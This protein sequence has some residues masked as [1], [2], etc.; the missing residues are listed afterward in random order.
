MSTN[1]PLVRRTHRIIVDVETTVNDEPS[2]TEDARAE[3]VR[4]HQALV[5]HL[6][7]HPTRLE[8]L[9]RS[10][11]VEALLPAKKLLEAEYGWGRTSDQQVL[12]PII[13]ELEPGARP[14]SPKSSRTGPACTTSMAMPRPS[15]R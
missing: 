4:F 14:T 5:Q 2:E 12:Q 1:S 9:L 7:A 6:L 10:S 8:Q 15:N 11:A 13:A 3:Q